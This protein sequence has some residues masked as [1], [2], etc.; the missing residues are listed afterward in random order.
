M[1]APQGRVDLIGAGPGDVE[2]MTLKAVKALSEADVVLVD[3]LVSPDVLA[4]ARSDALITYVGK[5]GGQPSTPQPVI[6]ELMLAHVHAGRRVARLKGGDPFVFGRGGEEMQALAAEGVQVGV[7]H[8][9]TAGIAAPAAIGIPLTHRDHAMGVVFV[10][11]HGASKDA[12]SG[13]GSREPDWAALAATKMTLVIY[14]GMRRLADIVAALIAAGLDPQTPAAA[15]E[16][17]TRPEQR[18]LL[19]PLEKLPDA[20]KAAALGAPAIVVI[21][22]VA[23]LGIASALDASAGTS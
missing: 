20:V 14:M 19:A 23:G 11:G 3:D 4:F 2:L 22:S 16:A 5:R 10:T 6:L 7:I 18:H 12:G 17:A 13:D 21:G 15:I 8:G 9:I 1:T